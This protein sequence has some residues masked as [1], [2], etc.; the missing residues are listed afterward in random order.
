MSGIPTTPFDEREGDI[1]FDGEFVP[2]RSAKVHVLTHGLHYASC[3]FEGERA[4]AGRI[5]K[6]KEH[7]DRLMYSAQTLGFRVPFGVDELKRACR[8]LIKRN[9]M[10]DSYLRPVAWRGT[11]Q[12]S[13]SARHTRIHVAIACWAWPSY[14][15]AAAKLRGIS[16]KTAIWR[17]PP[18]CSSPYQAKASAHYMIATLSK[19]DAE[20]H[21]FDDALM[22]DSQGR[23][24]EATSANVFF[25][26]GKEMHTPVA[27]C[28]LNGITRQVVIKIA[29]QRGYQ[30]I[31]RSI[32]YAELSSFDECFLTGTA[33][34]VT[35]VRQ[36]DGLH[37]TPAKTCIEMIDAYTHAVMTEGD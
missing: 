5:F 27:D 17:R 2:W 20:E 18:A 9:G 32:D 30:V 28:F 36:I 24:A 25:V 16:L 22:L 35:P 1:W 4:Y 37:F 7:T 15:E 11:E 8:D 26:R 12:I 19:H 31:E 10:R 6:L 33:A 21:G 14:F 29:V 34:E 3:V 23:I 13:T